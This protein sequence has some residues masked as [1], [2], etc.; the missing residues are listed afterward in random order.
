MVAVLTTS[1]VSLAATVALKVTVAVSPA[2]R[3]TVKVQ[4]DPLGLATAQ[5]SDA[6]TA[7]VG[8][9]WTA[10]LDGTSSVIVAEPAP[11]PTFLMAIVYGMVEP[12]GTGWPLP[13]T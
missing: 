10:R 11:S 9:P 5:V 7:H 2:A 4:V 13:G 8:V 12:G 3:L 6:V 1:A